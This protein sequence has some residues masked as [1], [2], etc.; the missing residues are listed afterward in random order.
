MVHAGEG[1]LVGVHGGQKG[2]GAQVI[3]A[4]G[5]FDGDHGDLAVEHLEL[6]AVALGL[7]FGDE[8]F[9]DDEGELGGVDLAL[10]GEGGELGQEGFSPSEVGGVAEEQ[11]CGFR[12]LRTDEGDGGP[13]VLGDDVFELFGEDGVDLGEVRGDGGAGG[14]GRRSGEAAGGLILLQHGE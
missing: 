11:G 12:G 5:V 4:A 10:V 1:L 9:V 14:G 8:L 13:A 2:A 7:S 3:E 6:G